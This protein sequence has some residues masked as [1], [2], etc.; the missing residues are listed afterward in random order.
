MVLQDVALM[1]QGLFAHAALK[2]TTKNKTAASKPLCEER[3]T[4]EEGGREKVPPNILCGT[5]Y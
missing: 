5:A 3:N 2:V 4:P 1:L